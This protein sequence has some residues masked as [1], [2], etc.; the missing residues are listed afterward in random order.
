[1]IVEPAARVTRRACSVSHLGAAVI[2]LSSIL[3]RAGGTADMRLRNACTALACAVAVAALPAGPSYAQSAEQHAVAIQITGV[4][5]QIVDMKGLIAAGAS[6]S[7]AKS[8]FLQ[9][10]RPEWGPLFVDAI[11]EEVAADEPAMEGVFA[12][13]LAKHLS[14]DELRA[15]LAIMSD[16]EM[17]KVIR[18]AARHEPAPPTSNP[19]CGRACMKAIGSPAGTAFMDKFSKIDGLLDANVTR[20]LAVLILPGVFIRFGEKAKAYEKA[21][22]PGG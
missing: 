4:M 12:D 18:A 20:D 8:N 11:N 6:S 2:A 15:G 19:P 14:A 21:H 3:S 7:L 16:T 13:V 10:T 5:F 17:Q 1:M 22:Q 9:D